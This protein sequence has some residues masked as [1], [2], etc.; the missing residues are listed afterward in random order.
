MGL[1]MAA[2]RLGNLATGLWESFGN[3]GVT[4]RSL[5]S[6]PDSLRARF[7]SCGHS[8]TVSTGYWGQR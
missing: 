4:P 3:D 8:A 1:W 5:A 6:S 7:R 2:M